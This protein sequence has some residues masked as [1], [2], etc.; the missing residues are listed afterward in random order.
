MA[1][2]TRRRRMLE[3]WLCRSARAAL[4]WSRTRLAKESG[5]S[6]PTIQRYERGDSGQL[7]DT[8]RKLRRALERGG[9]EFLEATKDRGPGLALRGGKRP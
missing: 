6:A 3:P 8:V 9:V 5:V 1:L 2:P 4:G 7:F